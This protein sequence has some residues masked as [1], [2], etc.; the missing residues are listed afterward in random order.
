MTDDEKPEVATDFFVEGGVVFKA[1]CTRVQLAATVD[2][3][4]E[5]GEHFVNV[6]ILDVYS[7]TNISR[8]TIKTSSIVIIGKEM[9]WDEA[10]AETKGEE[11]KS[12]G[13]NVVP[14]EVMEQL[15]QDMPGLFGKGP[16]EEEEE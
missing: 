8:V 4:V 5:G 2:K 10:V 13:S 1:A 11:N 14:D 6:N 16:D 12:G 7:E 9:D 3:A 15:R